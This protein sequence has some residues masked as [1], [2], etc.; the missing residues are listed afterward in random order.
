MYLGATSRH[1]YFLHPHL[2][3][4]IVIMKTGGTAIT[5]FKLKCFFSDYFAFLSATYEGVSVSLALDRSYVL[6]KSSR[7]PSPA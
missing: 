5:S 7:S 4:L 6:N 1:A 2:Y 3:F